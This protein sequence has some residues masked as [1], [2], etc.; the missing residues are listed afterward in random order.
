MPVKSSSLVIYN[1]LG[2]FP[3]QA[4]TDSDEPGNIYI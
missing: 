2:I 4:L 1:Y 3:I